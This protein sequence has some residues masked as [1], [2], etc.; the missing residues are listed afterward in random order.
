MAIGNLYGP[1][2]RVS[3]MGIRRET[4]PRNFVGEPIGTRLSEIDGNP[5]SSRLCSRL[6]RVPAPSLDRVLVFSSLVTRSIPRECV[7]ERARVH[8]ARFPTGRERNRG[9]EHRNWRVKHESFALIDSFRE[10][11]R[12]S[13]IKSKGY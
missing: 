12:A 11:S 1:P 13:M 6:L 9:K 10:H 7:C 4:I 3:S 8:R 5:L 2:V